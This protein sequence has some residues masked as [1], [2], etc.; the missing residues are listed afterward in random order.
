MHCDGLDR[1]IYKNRII[2]VNKNIY[3]VAVLF[4]ARRYGSFI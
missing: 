4:V 1:N 3:V 2:Y